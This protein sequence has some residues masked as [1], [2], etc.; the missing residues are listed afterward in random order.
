MTDSDTPRGSAPR[1]R[2]VMIAGALAVV[3]TIAGC[4]SAKSEPPRSSPSTAAATP[5]ARTTTSTTNGATVTAIKTAYIKFFNPATSLDE[6]VTLLQDGPAF[7]G[8]L[9]KQAKTSFAKTTT[10]T[11]S[12]VTLDSPNKATVVYTL[13]LAGTPVLV[14]T[15]GSAV[16]ESGKW[17]VAGATFC[18]LLTAQGPPP[19]VCARATETSAPK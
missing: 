6:S 1:R 7:R 16:H 4:S 2:T 13:L 5:I 15:T 9:K 3:A 12:T 11:V 10:A 17:K 14:D 8:T 19:P 18:G